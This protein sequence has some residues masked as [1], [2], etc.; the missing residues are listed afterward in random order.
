MFESAFWVTDLEGVN[1]LKHTMLEHT[2]EKG[3]IS[4]SIPPIH[5]D[6]H[7][8]NVGQRHI[9]L[10]VERRV[11]CQCSFHLDTTQKLLNQPW[12][13]ATF[14]TECLSNNKNNPEGCSSVSLIAHKAISA[15][16]LGPRLHLRLRRIYHQLTLDCVCKAVLICIFS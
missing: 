5:W 11:W 14:L 16:V 3:L 6:L 13:E 4:F 1:F 12:Y 9:Q 8:V 7:I 15:E 10:P 2:N